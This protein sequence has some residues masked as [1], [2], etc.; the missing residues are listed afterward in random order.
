MSDE[1]QNNENNKNQKEEKVQKNA[2]ICPACGKANSLDSMFCEDC[3]TSLE[4]TEKQSEPQEVEQDCIQEEVYQKQAYEDN[5]VESNVQSNPDV[6]VCQNCKKELTKDDVFCNKCGTKIEQEPPKCPK[7]GLEYKKG[8]DAFC[9]KCGQNLKELDTQS[10]V[11]TKEPEKYFC[12]QCGNEYKAGETFCGECGA[13]LPPTLNVVSE[14]LKTPGYTPSVHT[15]INNSSYS[16]DKPSYNHDKVK[17][18]YCKNE[19]NR[20]VKKCPHCGEWLSGVSHFGC[21][22]FLVLITTIIAICLAVGGESVGI[23]LIGEIGG[24]WLVI[25]AFLYFLPSLISDWR[26]HDSKF[27]IFIVN[28]FFGWTLIGWFAALIFSFTGRSR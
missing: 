21:G 14:Q 25:T 8:E 7:C 13:K 1:M 11:A 10:I 16:Y 2:K 28:L 24:I 6:V 23:P 27:A 12:E 18:P 17:C 4:T 3:G 20:Y 5:S 22:S 9:R 15:N 26:G 19:I